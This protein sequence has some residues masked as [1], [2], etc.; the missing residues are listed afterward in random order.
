MVTRHGVRL[1]AFLAQPHPESAV[2]HEHVLNL[3]GERRADARERID[4]EGNQG[5]VAQA[6]RR[7]RLGLDAERSWIVLSESNPFDWPGPDLRRVGDRED[8][9]VAYGLLPP[10]LFAEVRLRHKAFLQLLTGTHR[11]PVR[12]VWLLGNT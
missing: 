12:Y 7:R 3:H 11:T 8:S 4:H 5:A 10:R 2:L 1:A 9:S 6:G